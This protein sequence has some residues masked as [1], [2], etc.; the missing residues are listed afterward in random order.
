MNTPTHYRH[1]ATGHRN[2]DTDSLACAQAVAWW[3]RAAGHPRPASP[4]RLGEP[5]PQARWLFE[6]CGETLPELRTDCRILARD[7]AGELPLLD[8]GAP[9][10]EALELLHRKGYSLVGVSRDG[11]RLDGLIAESLPRTAFVLQMNLEDYLGHVLTAEG[12]AQGLKLTPLNRL[13]AP[14]EARRIQVAAA[15]PAVLRSQLAA[16]DVVICSAYAEAMAI[17]RQA[18]AA[19]VILAECGLEAAR[20][21]A[22]GAGLPCFYFSGSLMALLSQL[23]GCLPCGFAMEEE[24]VSIKQDCLLSQT[25]RYFIKASHGLP[26]VGEGGE[27]AG[28]LAMSSL[29]NPPEVLLTLVD[30]CDQ[31]LSI[32]GLEEARIVEVIDHHRLS[33]IESIEPLRIDC[34]PWG[35]TAAIIADRL[36]E[37]GLTPP[38]GLARLLLG[39]ILS[40]TLNLASPTTTVHDRE[41][42]SRLA[43]QSGVEWRSWG[44]EL[45]THNERLTTMDPVGLIELDGKEFTCGNFRFY[46]CQ[47]ETSDLA[48][49]TPGIEAG[50]GE[51][52]L[53]ALRRKGW[54]LAVAMVTDVTRQRSRLL[55]AAPDAAV[56]G[57]LPGHSFAPD[58]LAWESA[59]WVSRKKQLIPFLLSQ[60]RKLQP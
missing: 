36:E 3:H 48:R 25:K 21:L 7:V 58:C 44:M 28:Q 10:I 16:G 19:S 35:S 6:H 49:L 8:P 9:L 59:D 34:R 57:L 29:I 56:R 23:P 46:A 26:I 30:H 53:A 52:L 2:P 24:F 42:A 47:I 13:P 33:G 5:S 45:L 18:G 14:G 20:G 60:L 55:A 15:S 27:A 37:E 32:A 4:V 39:A 51:A 43:A 1:Y 12:L 54:G 31:S 11:R 40:D 17:A 50:L 38:P 41:W 22:E